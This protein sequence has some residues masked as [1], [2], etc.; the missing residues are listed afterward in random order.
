MAT[1]HP[2]VLSALVLAGLGACAYHPPT[3][4]GE[5]DILKDPVPPAEFAVRNVKVSPEDYNTLLGLGE[6]WFRYGAF[7]NEK[8]ISDVMGVFGGTVTIPCAPGGE[9]G[10]GGSAAGGE[11][12]GTGC[13][14]SKPVMPYLFAAIDDLDGVQGNLFQGN[15]GKDGTGYTSDL[16]I[17]FPPGTLLL[18]SVPV[19]EK[20]HT[21]LDIEAGSPWP[22]GIDPVLATGA[23]AD[24]PWIPKPSDLGYADAPEGRYRLRLA[25][26]ACHYSLD[27]DN[28]GKADIRSAK[29]DE[30]TPGS[31]YRPDHAWG[32]GNQDISFGWLFSLASNPLLGTPVLAGALGEEGPAPAIE[33]LNWVKANYKA[34]REEVEREVVVGMLAQPRGFADVTT[35]GMFNAIQLPTLYT[36]HGWPANSE[37]G[38]SNGTDRNNTVW[39]GALDFT[40]LINLCSDRGGATKLPWEQ[41]TVFNT[42]SCDDFVDLMTRYAPATLHDP[43]N[44]DILNKDILGTSDG[45]PG[46]L[47]PNSMV[48]MESPTVGK[49]FVDMPINEGRVR[50]PADFGGDSKYRGAGMAA[51]GM[52]IAVE[53]QHRATLEPFATKYGLDVEDLM[54]ESVSLALDWMD[55][56][57]NVSPLLAKAAGQVPAGYAVFRDAGCVSCHRGPYTTD[58]VIHPL[59]HDPK[60]QFGGPRAPTTAGWRVLDRGQGPAIATEPQRTWNTRS[61][62]R[63]VSPPYDPATGEATREGGVL[64]GLLAVQQIGYKTT[65]LRYLWASAPYLH[66][67]GVA[68]GLRPG[69]ASEGD[70]LAALLKR[71]GTND[72]IYGIGE[73]L[74]LAEADPTKGPKANAALSLQ[75]L[76]LESE[77]AKVIAAN[78]TEAFT[79]WP[80]SKKRVVGEGPPVTK[81]SMKSVGISGIGHEFWIDDTPGGEKVTSLVAFLLALDDCP[82][83]LPGGPDSMRC[84]NSAVLAATTTP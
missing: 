26:A 40:G 1:P 83:D 2:Y 20:L 75:A 42:L 55:P 81:V 32:V 58:N 79:V 57:P 8:S 21:G 66:D 73:I 34:N 71:A 56:P 65:P 76:V 69:A 18:G 24:S 9:A 19:P 23:D 10:G 39:T 60:D 61:L 68:I 63:F 72:L 78:E 80:G 12:G 35:D 59:S 74:S 64:Y 84:D 47:A 29:R 52:R 51:L 16:V 6:G 7:G 54:S 27:I 82:R 22:I 53:P 77:R 44:Q 28:D 33:F 37:G 46:M 62:R 49:T 31:P 48:V 17:T 38:Q 41:E 70:D 36:R 5:Y 11:A 14:E 67:G 4:W 3:D 43:K 45:V 13:V 50:K 25:C 15:G 30:P